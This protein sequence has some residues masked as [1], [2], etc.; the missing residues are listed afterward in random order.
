[1]ANLVDGKWFYGNF[2]WHIF[3]RISGFGM[4]QVVIEYPKIKR[5]GLS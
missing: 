4:I 2:L 5:D 1:M 3:S